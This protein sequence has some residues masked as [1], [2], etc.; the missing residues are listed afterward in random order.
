VVT[1]I[2]VSSGISKIRCAREKAGGENADCRRRNGENNVA[3]AMHHHMDSYII[4][5]NEH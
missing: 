3:L 2:I 5:Q 4:Y 1:I